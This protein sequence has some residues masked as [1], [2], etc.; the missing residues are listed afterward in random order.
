VLLL[1]LLLATAVM[2]QR[3]LSSSSSS[4]S[5]S[6]LATPKFCCYSALMLHVPHLVPTTQTHCPACGRWFACMQAFPVSVT[7]NCNDLHSYALLKM[8][9]A[10]AE[11]VAGAAEAIESAR[12][13]ECERLACVHPR[14]VSTFLNTI[15]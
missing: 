15:E 10:A 12:G 8:P 7:E 3:Y 6:Y 13:F 14:Y 11:L 9:E 1:L 2:V 5:S 4:S